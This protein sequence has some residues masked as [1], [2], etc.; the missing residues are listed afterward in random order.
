MVTPDQCRAA[1]ALLG[2]SANDVATAA[3]IGI[4]TVKR[5]EGGQAVQPATVATI[6]DA[7]T[8]A[9][10]E[11]IASGERSAAGGAGVRLRG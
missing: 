1:R 5:F 8:E 9:G 10:V 7:L 11:I 6:A 2:W 3:K 4:A